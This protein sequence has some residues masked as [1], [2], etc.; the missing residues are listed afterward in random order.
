L[1]T[2]PNWGDAGPDSYRQLSSA[3]PAST[4][5]QVPFPYSARPRTCCTPTRTP[6]PYGL[7]S[8]S[9]LLSDGYCQ[10]LSS[11]REPRLHQGGLQALRGCGLPADS[12]TPPPAACRRPASP[13]R[14]G[15]A[16]ALGAWKPG[17]PG[18]REPGSQPGS[19]R[20]GRR[21][22]DQRERAAPPAPARLPG[23]RR[24]RPLRPTW[25]TAARHPK[26]LGTP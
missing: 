1:Q 7:P 17:S 14:R 5:E 6:R 12:T 13:R 24:F 26:D 18:T 3:I 8:P 23:R 22:T 16:P 9:P 10:G 15:R 2:Q 19:F 20:A 11:N 25:G 4:P 21:E